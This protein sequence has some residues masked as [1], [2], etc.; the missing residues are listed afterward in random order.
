MTSLQGKL[1][2]ATPTLLDPN[3][4][5]AVV[6][7]ASH[8]D[9]GALGL[10]LN[11]PSEHRAAEMVPALANVLAATETLFVGGPVQPDAVVLLAEFSDL[12]AR[13]VPVTRSV[14]LVGEADELGEL[15]KSTV[16]QRAF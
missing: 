14:G 9:E 6:A 15:A 7:I 8:D 16:R 5:R 12:S 1:L 4:A 3:F 11:R 10:V 13:H 2:I